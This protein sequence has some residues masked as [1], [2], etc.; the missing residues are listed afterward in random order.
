MIGPNFKS[1]DATARY[2][3]GQVSLDDK[4]NAYRYV[5]FCEGVT[6]EP[7]PAAPGNFVFAFAEGGVGA[8]VDKAT[9]NAGDSAGVGLGVLQNEP[10][11]DEFCW[12]Q[13]SGLA[14]LNDIGAAVPGNTLTAVGAG[15]VGGL[16]VNAAATSPV[17]AICLDATTKQV[18]LVGMV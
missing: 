1:I 7:V 11:D 4:G 8:R 2:E 10:K 14:T 12:V 17:C 16:A 18:L 9:T 3:P 5:Q 15:V 6:G 13:C